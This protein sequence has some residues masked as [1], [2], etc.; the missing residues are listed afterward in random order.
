MTVMYNHLIIIAVIEVG[1]KR[2]RPKGSADKRKQPFKV[3]K[4]IASKG[5]FEDLKFKVMFFILLFINTFVY[6]WFKHFFYYQL[7]RCG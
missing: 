1:K 6:N 2:G 3:L 7:L 5:T 4:K